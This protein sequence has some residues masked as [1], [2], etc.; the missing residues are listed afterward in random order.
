MEIAI[1]QSIY[2][3]AI[4]LKIRYSTYIAYD[5]SSEMVPARQN[6]G[7]CVSKIGAVRRV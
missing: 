4:P 3:E 5:L 7:G 2:T 6:L 1:D